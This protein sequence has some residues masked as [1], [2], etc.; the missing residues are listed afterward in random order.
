MLPSSAIRII[1]RFIWILTFTLDS[2]GLK[3]VKKMPNN[4][5]N[6][7]ECKNI[8]MNLQLGKR[9]SDEYVKAA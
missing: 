3:N 6:A 4:N 5:I 8:I 9:T 2:E 1:M 7:L